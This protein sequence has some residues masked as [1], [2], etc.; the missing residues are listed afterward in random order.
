MRK[1]TGVILA[2]C[3][4]LNAVAQQSSEVPHCVNKDFHKEVEK[5]L[6]GSVPQID[7]DKLYNNYSDYQ[8]LD[9]REMEEYQISH[10][11]GASFGG[12]D[13]FSMDNLSSFDTNMP[14][15]VYC[16]IGY[17]SEKIGEKLA[18]AGYKR[19]F[20]LYGSIFEW[21]N[22]GYPL[23]DPQGQRTNRLHTYNKSWSRWVDNNA[24]E[25]LW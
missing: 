12:Y 10:L 15:V 7:V 19:V 6:E 14:I 24:V 8:I 18:A 5:T 23:D 21:A 20:N 17:R 11:P 22:R 2:L 9:A 1:V 4:V 13:H 3:L 16:S 25:L